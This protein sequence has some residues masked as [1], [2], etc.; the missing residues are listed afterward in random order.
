MLDEEKIEKLLKVISG[1]SGEY[2]I[3]STHVDPDAF[4]DAATLKTIIEQKKKKIKVPIYFCDEVDPG[5]NIKIFETLNL[6]KTMKPISELDQS[7]LTQFALVDANSIKDGRMPNNL[8]FD[9]FPRPNIIIDHHPS[10]AVEEDNEF[11]W[12]EEGLGS[13]STMMV[14]LVQALDIDLSKSEIDN[15]PSLLSVGIYTDTNSLVNCTQRDNDAFNAMRKIADYDVWRQLTTYKIPRSLMKHEKMVSESIILEKAES[16]GVIVA[17]IG[18]V[19]AEEINHIAFI[20][21]RMIRYDGINQIYIWCINVATSQIIISARSS[22][23]ASKSLKEKLHDKLGGK[24]GTRKIG[25]ISL[26]GGRL[27]FNTGDFG[28]LSKLDKKCQESFE[29]LAQNVME[30]IFLPEKEDEKK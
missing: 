10:S 23:D 28:E 3:L 25:D 8:D 1:I 9:K 7:K 15:L 5:Q 17:G 29:Q 26:G 2:P 21:N 16:Q 11:Y 18:F 27:H 4:A 20:A 19:N 22:T 14:E 13:A 24:S 12:I 30:S 6:A